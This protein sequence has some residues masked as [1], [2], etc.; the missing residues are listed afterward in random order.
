[1]RGPVFLRGEELDNDDVGLDALDQL[2]IRAGLRRFRRV[3]LS[4]RR[5]TGEL[6]GVALAY[7][8]PLGLNFSFLENRCDLIVHRGLTDIELGQVGCALLCRAAPVYADFEPRILPV[9]TDVDTGT[10]L[11][12]VGAAEF[13]R[14]YAQSVWLPKGYLGWYRHVEAF[15]GRILQAERRRGF[16]A[17]QRE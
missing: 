13:V 16:A 9:V 15:Y 11:V 1:V 12:H 14:E 8:G 3:F 7:R 10:A 17:R 6:V 2:Y 4:R 5:S